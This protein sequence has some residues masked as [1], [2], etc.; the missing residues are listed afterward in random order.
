MHSEHGA[1]ARRGGASVSGG[2]VAAPDPGWT[3]DEN[4]A[5]PGGSRNDGHRSSPNPYAKH[6]DDYRYNNGNDIF[7]G[8]NNGYVSTGGWCVKFIWSFI[9]FGMMAG[10]AIMFLSNHHGNTTI[11][12]KTEHVHGKELEMLVRAIDDKPR[13]MAPRA[14]PTG[15]TTSEDSSVVQD[16]DKSPDPKAPA[17]NPEALL[18]QALELVKLATGNKNATLDN[19]RQAPHETAEAGDDAVRTQDPPE[20]EAAQQETEGHDS[21]VSLEAS[22]AKEDAPATAHSPA[23]AEASDAKPG[24]WDQEGLATRRKPRKRSSL[25]KASKL[26][27]NAAAELPDG[28]SVQVEDV[29]STPNPKEESD[30]ASKSADDPDAASNS[31]EE[32]DVASKST[33]DPDVASKSADEPD[34]ES[35]STEEPDVESKSTDEPDVASKSTEEPDVASKSTEERDAE[36]ARADDSES[37]PNP[38]DEPD[39]ASSHSDESSTVDKASQQ[40]EEQSAPSE[41]VTNVGDGPADSGADA[42]DASLSTDTPSPDVPQGFLSAEDVARLVGG[43]DAGDAAAP[44]GVTTAPSIS[45]TTSPSAGAEVA[46]A[47]EELSKHEPSESAAARPAPAGKDRNCAVMEQLSE[48]AHCVVRTELPACLG[49]GGRS[50][51]PGGALTLN[52]AGQGNVTEELQQM[53]QVAR[54]PMPLRDVLGRPR[55]TLRPAPSCGVVTHS[56]SLIGRGLG[57]RIDSNSVVIRTN[58]APTSGFEADV[59]SF[60]TLRYTDMRQFESFHQSSSEVVVAGSWCSKES[61]D[62]MDFE[63]VLG[64]FVHPLNPA[65]KQW[66]EEPFTDLKY[67][68]SASFVAMLLALHLCEEVNVY[69]FDARSEIPYQEQSDQYHSEIDAIAQLNGDILSEWKF[70]VCPLKEKGKCVVRGAPGSA[71]KTKKPKNSERRKL[72]RAPGRSRSTISSIKGKKRW[73]PPPA[74][75]EKEPAA[76]LPALEESYVP[77]QPVVPLGVV[78][79]QQCL[80]ELLDSKLVMEVA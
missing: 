62:L 75:P 30:V 44:L 4:P 53:A 58:D 72:L 79:E 22:G 41:M 67:Q 42:V 78:K 33:A 34:V 32:P 50:A 71:S 61:C 38:N 51:F 46:G 69:G 60:T 37:T 59:G 48:D 74:V 5:S 10:I 14:E 12:R 17:S 13:D 54:D 36:S 20:A 24:G 3:T 31:S 25:R 27:P 1:Y 56:R 40:S 28:G 7:D 73:T 35:N 66:A 64:N 9:A 15:I 80:R 76:I 77:P 39:M 43:D 11:A 70:V 6:D 57:E 2:W 65:F 26:A 29:D 47:A 55:G 49:L 16:T 52:K 23:E 45:P 68:P 8:Q 18:A 63:R 19:L 21:A